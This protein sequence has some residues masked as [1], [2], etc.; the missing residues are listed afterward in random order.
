MGITAINNEKED[1]FTEQDHLFMQRSLELAKQA[2]QSG[3]VPV[4]AVLVSE[5][6]IIGEGFNS[7]IFHHDPTAH[8]EILAIRQAAIKEQNYRLPKTT[9]YVTLEP[10]SMC[11]GAMVHSRIERLVFAAS[12]NK[13]GACGSVFNVIS[14]NDKAHRV[15]CEQGLLAEESR[16]LLT[17]FFKGRRA[18]KKLRIN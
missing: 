15:Q 4:G 5:G 7:C 17:D 11:A 18:E 1:D 6:E 12:D 10:C 14:S 9:L 2:Q 16:K 13:T 8:A 3:E